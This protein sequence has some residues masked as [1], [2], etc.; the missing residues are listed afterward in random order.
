MRRIDPTPCDPAHTRSG[1]SPNDSYEFWCGGAATADPAAPQRLVVRGADLL[2]Q[3]IGF[4]GRDTVMRQHAREDLDRRL[5]LLRDDVVRTQPQELGD[6]HHV[7]RAG[8]DVHAG[9]DP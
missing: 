7:P 2:H 9:I 3:A 6:L 4:P 8:D 5:E 1:R